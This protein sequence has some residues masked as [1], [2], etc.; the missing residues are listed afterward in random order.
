M[1]ERGIK[2]R[3]ATVG[4]DKDYDI[5]EFVSDLEQLGIGAHV[6]RVRKVDSVRDAYGRG[7]HATRRMQ[8]PRSLARRGSIVTLHGGR[9]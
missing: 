8:C 5:D 7:S 2:N 3:E 1:I 4:T 6:A 9:G